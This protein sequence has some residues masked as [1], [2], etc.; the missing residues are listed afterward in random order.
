MKHLLL[1]AALFMTCLAAQAQTDTTKQY[2]VEHLKTLD[3][4]NLTGI[5]LSQVTNLLKFMPKTAL[6]NN[7]V[8]SNKFTEKHWD[9]INKSVDKTNKVYMEMY[10]DIIPYADKENLI[11]AIMWLQEV[12]LQMESI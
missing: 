6:N 8:P 7:D 11:D 4:Q 12:T 10:K 5:Y 3:K 9:T 1:T 2:Q